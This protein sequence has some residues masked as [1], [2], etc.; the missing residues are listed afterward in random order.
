MSEDVVERIIA[1]LGAREL[2]REDLSAR[3]LCKFLGKTTGILYHHFGSVD[4]LLFAVSQRGIGIMREHL[5]ASLRKRGELADVAEAFV[6]F[7]LDH[8]EL[9][10]LMFEHRFD[11]A[12]LREQGAFEK[13][14]PGGHLWDEM[15]KLLDRAG[16]HD[17]AM[18]ARILWAGL[19]GLVSLAS[20]GRANMRALDR[21]D[22]EV[23]RAGARVLAR[24]IVGGSE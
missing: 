7:G 10:G 15:I 3:R 22:R 24:R 19:H 17:P 12:A 21:T 6:D 11:W 18:D 5:E 20:S 9:Y 13:N 8:P 2:S 1:G 16:S 14:V 23:A 4:G